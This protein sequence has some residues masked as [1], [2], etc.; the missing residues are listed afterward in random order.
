MDSLEAERRKNMYVM[1]M[2][3]ITEDNHE[4]R[5]LYPNT[6]V[7]TEFN[8]AFLHQKNL[9]QTATNFIG[10]KHIDGSPRDNSRQYANPRPWNIL[11][12]GIPL[13]RQPLLKK[14]YA[15]C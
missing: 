2:H 5:R 13:Q 7:G 9:G 10:V 3:S 14:H 6:N 4:K 8:S 1:K 12:S 15:I 11:E